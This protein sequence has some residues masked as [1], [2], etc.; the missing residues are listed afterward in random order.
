M[1]P[2]PTLI[3]LALLCG[4]SAPIDA[5]ADLDPRSDAAIQ[6]V[7]TVVVKIGALYRNKQYEQAITQLERLLGSHGVTGW[8]AANTRFNLALVRQA[9]GQTDAALS[10]FGLAV[11]LGWSDYLELRNTPALSE[12]F[13][14][15]AFQKL[16]KRMCISPADAAELQWLHAE[17]QAV[18]HDTRMMI[19]ANQGRLDRGWTAVWPSEI[20]TRTTTA[21]SV[22]IGRAVLAWS[23]G[24][25]RQLVRASDQSRINHLTQMDI[26]RNMP[27]GK[28]GPEGDFE[29]QQRLA[30]ERRRREAIA[31]SAR[32]AAQADAARRAAVAGRAFKPNPQLSTAPVAC[33]PLGKRHTSQPSD[34][35]GKDDQATG[36]RRSIVGEWLAYQRTIYNGGQQQTATLTYKVTAVTRTQVQFTLTVLDAAGNRSSSQETVPIK[37]SLKAQLLADM[38]LQG[39][40]QLL[41][42][43]VGRTTCNVGGRQL[44]VRQ[45]DMRFNWTLKG[46]QSIW[47]A[48]LLISPEV[49]GIGYTFVEMSTGQLRI[50]LRLQRYGRTRR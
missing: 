35:P 45:V 48:R 18:G 34:K 41:S 24:R 16:Y 46:Q 38:R 19:T 43:E 37:N 5:G 13:S 8:R 1:R 21:A 23:L 14:E 27:G 7:Q 39:P 50:R 22:L 29:R 20:P 33:P 32:K 11:S 3:C 36:L 10:E 44:A 47:Q 49:P 12:L 28:S 9:A 25:Q 6:Y 4:L 2:T 17:I 26:T 15:P 31:R 42:Y 40:V 30:R